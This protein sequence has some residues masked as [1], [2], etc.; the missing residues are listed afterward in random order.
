M[1]I[2]ARIKICGL[3]C[4]VPALCICI[5]LFYMQT[6]RHGEFALKAEK[7][8]YTHTAKDILRGKI[9]DR[10]GIVLA[11]SLK[12][13]S[14]GISKRNVN[15]KEALLNALAKT[16]DITKAELN[17]KWNKSRNFF[18]AQK[19]VTPLQYEA[20]E[21]IVR[22]K[23]LTGIE[24]EDEYTRIYPFDGIAQ[25]IIGAT[26]SKNTGLSGI[27]L[28]YNKELAQETKS[29]R[30]KKSADGGIIYDK[31]L[32]YTP[33]I[34]DIRLTINALG[35][36]YAESTLKKYAQEYKVKSAFVIVQEPHT[37]DI[38]AAASYPARDGRSLPFQFTY[39][40][41]S[42]FKTITV[43]AALDS[44][45]IKPNASYDMENNAWRTNGVTIRDSHKQKK[46]YLSVGEIM[47]QSSNIGA[48]KIADE[49]GSKL[50][51]TYVKK[52]GFG[53]KSNVSFL[54]EPAGILRDYT[55]WQP[56]DNIKAGYGYTISVTGV[57]LVSA[58]S[59]IAN[60][61]E[62]MQA[63]L[64]DKIIYNTGEEQSFS[65]PIKVRR[66]VSEKTVKQITKML[67]GVVNEGTGKTAQ[68]A[69]YRVAGKTGT[70]EK[71]MQD[72]K[73]KRNAHIASFC[74]F[75][76]VSDPKFTILV[77]LDEPERALFGTASG[78]IF[79]DIAKKFLTLY[80]VKPDAAS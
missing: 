13:Y 40:P 11:E 59:A 27:E 2:K 3:L 61:G 35:Q 17:R 62:L 50:M 55:R 1:N 24:I 36:Y 52:F 56:I 70:T 63:H 46:D 71:M 48:G 14:I 54:G 9:V 75:L 34:A 4:F 41:G 53:I 38:L 42:T 76:P 32:D 65:D 29:A 19:G 21:N 57:Q 58:Y 45:K 64:V 25:D 6:F 60:G 51:F 74:G 30:V 37:G 10:N 15:D 22:S 7:R 20:F 77:V 39:E 43:A 31:S 8:A 69:G 26:N 68:V 44:G 80:A 66:V 47:E 67:E 78:Q 5:R 73:Y 33:K 28:I 12:T 49:L 16:T 79:A 18:Y 72:G 23:R